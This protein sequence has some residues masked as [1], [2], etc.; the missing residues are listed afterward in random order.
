MSLIQIIILV[1]ICLILLFLSSFFSAAETAYSTVNKFTIEHNLKKKRLSAKLIRKHYKSFGWILATILFGNN[2]VNAGLSSLTTLMFTAYFANNDTL[3]TL[4]SVLVITPVIVIF[5]EIIPKILAKKYAYGYL[6]KVVYVIEILTWIFLPLTFPFSKIVLSSKTAITEKEVKD[7]T[8]LAAKQ[9]QIKD[10]EALLVHKSLELNSLELRQIM[11]KKQQFVT[12][13]AHENVAKALTIFKQSGYSRLPML[14]NHK[15]IGVL[16]LKN[17]LNQNLDDL[18]ENFNVEI[19]FLSKNMSVT[20]ALEILRTEKSHIAFVGSNLQKSPSVTGLITLEDIFEEIFGEIYDEHDKERVINQIAPNK[21]IV[22]GSV[23][24][25]HLENIL[26]NVL[27]ENKNNLTIKQWVQK[28][29]NKKIRLNY[30][31]TYKNAVVFKVVFNKNNQTTKFEI[32][33]K[34]K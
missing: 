8:H 19:P 2:F 29:I 17:I 23:P 9:K 16:I 10:D 18:V 27:F 22:D 33:Q 30:K 21:W 14:K 34:L 31:Y 28:R 1:F 4:V 25:N 7:L 32:R 13:S 11:I 6:S 26:H 5:G 24:I 12:I 20:K 3:I 15:F